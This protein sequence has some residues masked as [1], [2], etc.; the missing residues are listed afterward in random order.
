M[1]IVAIR[2]EG[3]YEG[4]YV[5]HVLVSDKFA[6]MEEFEAAKTK[7]RSDQNSTVSKWSDEYKKNRKKGSPRELSWKFIEERLRENKMTYDDFLESNGF[8]EAPFEIV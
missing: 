8:K 2:E 7:W 5:S 1:Q 6:S 3:E 4:T